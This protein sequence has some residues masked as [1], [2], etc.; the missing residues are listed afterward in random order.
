MKKAIANLTIFPTGILGNALS[1]TL[2][3]YQEM[4]D[5]ILTIVTF[6]TLHST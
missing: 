4:Y 3:L 2:S 1:E 5:I 6:N